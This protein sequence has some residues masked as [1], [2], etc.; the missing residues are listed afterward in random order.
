MNTFQ[1]SLPINTEI[2]IPK[3]DPVR[4]LDEILETLDYQKLYK[5]YSDVGRPCYHLPKTLFKIAAYARMN[6]TFSSRKIEQACKRDINF[7]W[8]L[9]GHKAPDHNTISRFTNHLGDSMEDLFY[10]LVKKLG[11]MGEIAYENVYI[12]GT[13]I[14]SFANKY[15]FVWKKATQKNEVKLGKKIKT[16][17]DEINKIYGCSY[18]DD[19]SKA[20]S[21]QLSEIIEFLETK[22]ALTGIEFVYGKGKRKQPLQRHIEKLKEYFEAQS[23]YE[24][25]N[26]IFDGRN[27]FSKTD[28]DAT[29]MRMK[30]DHMRNAQLKPGY[31]VQIGVEGEYIVGVDIFSER[32]DQLTFLPF[33]DTLYENLPKKHTNVIADAGYESEENYA[34]LESNGQ[35]A[36]IKPSNYEIS[37][38]KSFR[39]KISLRENM[40]YNV[41]SDEY[42]CKNLKKLVHVRDTVKKSRSGYESKVKIYECESC[43]GCPYKV[44]CTKA[45]GN[46]ELQVSVNFVR[47]REISLKNITTDKGIKLRINRSIQVEGAFGV[48]KEDYGFRRF[49]MRGKKNV[50]TEFML[51]CFGYNI[52]K[53]HSKIV[54]NRCGVSLF[55]I[56]VA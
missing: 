22:K 10:Q 41:E 43:E 28:H 14:E 38:T 54:N 34:H 13:K 35:N 46:K 3:D 32:S 53:L 45:K 17:I 8:L 36:Y 51:L 27:S 33:L 7:I 19:E 48:L 11:D 4:L 24:E 40:T 52:N 21:S 44:K 12:D 47:L 56:S 5:S 29:F 23:K 39:E 16:L 49:L 55:E 18:T 2:L 25:Y 9:A 1:L 37:K 31:N 42:V 20:K 30:E 50:K 26:K 6:A 15:T